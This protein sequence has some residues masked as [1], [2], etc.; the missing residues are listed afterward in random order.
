MRKKE[1][2]GFGTMTMLEKENIEKTDDP[3]V[4]EFSQ[5]EGFLNG[6]SIPLKLTPNGFALQ[7]PLADK[8]GNKDFLPGKVFVNFRVRLFQL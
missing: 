3:D 1:T 8:E 6:P 7:N 5:S 4:F 2:L